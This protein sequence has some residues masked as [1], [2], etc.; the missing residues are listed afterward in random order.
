MVHGVVKQFISDVEWGELDYLVID[1]PPGTG[2]AA[3]TL[4][5]TAPLS[6]PCAG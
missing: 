4:T 3:L 1:L 5:Q 2:D 6:G